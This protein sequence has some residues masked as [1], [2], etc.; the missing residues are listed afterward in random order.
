MERAAIYIETYPF[1]P[2]VP[3]ERFEKL[4]AEQ[5]ARLRKPLEAKPFELQ[6]RACRAYCERM[7]YS[8][9]AVYR[10]NTPPPD[11]VKRTLRFRIAPEPIKVFYE[12]ESRHPYYWV[13]NLL[14][15]ET[16][17]LIV[18][19]RES[20]PSGNIW[21][22]ASEQVIKIMTRE[23]AA[24]LWEIEPPTETDLRKY[25]LVTAIAKTDADDEAAPLIAELKALL[26]QSKQTQEQAPQQDEAC[27][28]DIGQ[29]VKWLHKAERSLHSAKRSLSSAR[30]HAPA[31]QARF[32]QLETR[33][34]ALYQDV[35]RLA[36]EAETQVSSG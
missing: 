16:I 12:Y 27:S 4:N 23:E 32:V 17:D 11:N 24:S 7:G 2:D 10:A 19:F 18:T 26:A 36:A 5:V 28:S 15:M 1:V 30:K 35:Q 22:D 31:F 13:R 29:A 6:E 25:E 9:F 20:G 3:P 14:K 33:L 21:A 34:E 8:V